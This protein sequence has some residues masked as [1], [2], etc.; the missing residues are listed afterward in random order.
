MIFSTHDTSLLT[1][2]LLR[3]DQI[4]FAEKDQFGATCVYPLSSIKVRA[5]DNW[6]R[7][8]ING[9]FG[10]IPFLGANL[11]LRQKALDEDAL[12]AK[13][14]AQGLDTKIALALSQMGEVPTLPMESLE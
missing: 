6:E 11:L 3:R 5:T 12:N 13:L 4:W 7:G 1:S 9:R 8:Y 2:G 10:A 14:R